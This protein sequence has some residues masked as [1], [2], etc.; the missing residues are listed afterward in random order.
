M[1]KKKKSHNNTTK[2]TCAQRYSPTKHKGTWY[3]SEGNKI[4]NKKKYFKKL[5]ENG[6]YWRDC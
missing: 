6:K 1:G 3:D 2:Q 5:K 4:K